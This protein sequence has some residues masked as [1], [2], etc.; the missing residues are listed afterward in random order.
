MNEFTRYHPIVN[1][2]YFVCVIAFCCVF[3]HPVTLMIS[4]SASF[5]FFAMIKKKILK[6]LLLAIFTIIVMAAINPLFNHRGQ[7]I[8]TYFQSGNPLTL[9]SVFYG[10]VSAFMI[11]SVIIY[12]LCFNEIMNGSKI[13]YLFGRIAPTLALVFS[14][15]LSFVPRLLAQMKSADDSR[16]GI[17]NSSEK[18]IIGKIKGGLSNLAITVTWSLE[19]AIGTADSMKARGYGLAGRTSFSVYTFSKRDGEMLFATLI[20]SVY[21]II[22]AALGM[23]RFECF[24]TVSI[25]EFSPYGISVFAAYLM[26]CALPVVIELWEVKRWKSLK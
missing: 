19:N 2:I 6:P 22:G 1:L 7:T 13:A 5:S 20:L 24:P 12:F 16:K 3:L 23:L 14:M 21:I 26:L 4:F 11:V 25:A 17:G 10:I 15:V 18:S 9:E 8:L